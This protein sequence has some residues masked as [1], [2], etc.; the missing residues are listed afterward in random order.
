MSDKLIQG[1]VE[2][3]KDG[4]YVRYGDGI[5]DTYKMADVLQFVY[6]HPVL[7]LEE[8]R[9]R[10]CEF[11][12]AAELEDEQI[13]AQAVCQEKLI[14]FVDKALN[15]FAESV[16]ETVKQYQIEKGN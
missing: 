13:D 12:A 3:V 16:A 11:V 4:G 7:N 9:L 14:K 8:S 6:E 10:Y 5:S 1:I 2:V 15:L